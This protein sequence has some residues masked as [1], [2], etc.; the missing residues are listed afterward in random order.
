MFQ[1]ALISY[2]NS[3][4][5]TKIDFILGLLYPRFVF[6][7]NSKKVISLWQQEEKTDC[8]SSLNTTIQVSSYRGI[9]PSV[10]KLI[11]HLKNDLERDL[12]GAYL[13]G[14]LATQ[15]EIN[16]SDFDALVILKDDVFSDINS[17]SR[18]GLKLNRLQKVM[19]EF[20]SLQHHGW[21][22]LTES[23][24]KN[25][26]NSYFPL[27]L[28]KYSVSLLPEKGTNFDVHH[29]SSNTDF[30]SPFWI[31]SNELLKKLNNNYRPKNTFTLKSFLSEF[32]LLPSFYLQA[33]N[34]MAVYKKESF[35]LARKDFSEPDW[36][37]MDLISEIRKE[38]YYEISSFQKMLLCNRNAVVR[39]LGRK[40]APNIPSSIEIKLTATVYKAMSSLVLSMQDKLKSS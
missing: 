2:V 4:G 21:F 23:M 40:F 9:N 8:V 5:L 1:R 17:I 39:K 20:D 14:S 29:D 18:V 15:E 11:T 26:P 7:K 33:K 36:L 25:Y 22:V 27:E 32:M 34:N 24:L 19:H 37:V 3:G 10:L 35:E 12:F 31:L 38:W 30:K 6:Q 16:Y 28:F 13:H